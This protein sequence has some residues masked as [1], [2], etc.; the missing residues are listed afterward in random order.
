VSPSERNPLLVGVAADDSHGAALCYAADVAARE[1]RGIRLVHVFASPS[2][3]A[4]ES[5]LLTT[6]AAT[7][8]A[9]DL[10]HRA[11]DRL[12]VLDSTLKVQ[13][14]TR[15]G[16]VTDVLVE[17]GRAADR[18]ILEHR[19]QSRLLRVF[20][21]SVAAAVAARCAVPVVSVPEFWASWT[22]QQPQL[23]V[24]VH[25]DATDDPVLDR[26][27]LTAS[28]LHATLT[29]LHA[30]SLPA[31]YDNAILDRSA[32]RAWSRCLG[33][34]VTDRLAP[35]REAHPDLDVRIEVVHMRTVDALVNTS[36]HSDLLMLGR[37]GQPSRPTH[38]GSSSRALIRESLCPVEI[39][40]TPS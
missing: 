19:Q 27:F 37:N 14:A 3:R 2:G 36:R 20:N 31:V 9:E 25:G 5:V 39:V 26:A 28:A 34:R 38:L 17:M 35:R 30:W 21:G 33:A 6:E 12:L 8:V 18:V 40:P 11:K 13:P 16:Q 4:P 29:V 24:G 7:L 10:V 23:T 22:Q 1:H 32:L 15:C